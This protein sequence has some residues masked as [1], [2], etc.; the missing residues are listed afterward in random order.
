MRCCGSCISIKNLWGCKERNGSCLW[1]LP[2]FPWKG[3]LVGRSL[4]TWLGWRWKLKI[5]FNEGLSSNWL[6][7]PKFFPTCLASPVLHGGFLDFLIPLYGR[8]SCE[9]DQH[10][11]QLLQAQWGQAVWPRKLSGLW[12]LRMNNPWHAYKKLRRQIFNGFFLDVF[13]VIQQ[14]EPP[15]DAAD[16]ARSRSD[17]Q[18]CSVPGGTQI[19][20]R[21]RVL[22][23]GY[24]KRRKA[25]RTRCSKGSITGRTS[26]SLNTSFL[27]FLRLFPVNVMSA[28]ADISCP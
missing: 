22:H 1:V 6:W 2:A 12:T 15:E 4:N 18:P 11:S 19:I 16:V 20:C 24:S 25:I 10:M 13:R 8:A 23:V 14:F 28:G 9:N 5:C 7:Q 21:S 17:W 26:A 3:E 27:K